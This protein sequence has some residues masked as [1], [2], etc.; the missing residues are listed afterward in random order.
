MTPHEDLARY[1]G[2]ISP[3]AI[4]LYLYMRSMSE[5]ATLIASMAMLAEGLNR[6]V[7]YV[8]KYIAELLQAGLIQ[9]EHRNDERGGHL[10]NQYK[11][12]V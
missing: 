6:S 8:K 10:S 11:L 3:D 1:V 7:P 9:R 4:A 5:Q 2:T 12:L